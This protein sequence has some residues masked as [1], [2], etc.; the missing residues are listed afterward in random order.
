MGRLLSIA[1]SSA[2]WLFGGIGRIRHE[3]WEIWMMRIGLALLVFRATPPVPPKSVQPEPHGIARF[4][5]LTFLSRPDVYTPLWW[6]LHGALV[7]Y[8]LGLA[9]GPCLGFILAFVVATNSLELSQAFV[10]HSTQMEGLVLLAQLAATVWAFAAGRWRGGAVAELR[11]SR[12]DLMMDWTRQGIVASYVV[13]GI[14]KLVN[15]DGEWLNRSVF[16][17]LQV[18][19]AQAEHYYTSGVQ[20]NP[21]SMAFL[22]ALSGWPLLAG[23]FLT[24]GL[25][26]EL[27]AFLG[28]W[29]RPLGLIVGL[30]L[31]GFHV[32]LGTLMY[33]P[34]YESR[35]FVML[36]LVNP[37]WW[38]WLV[39]RRASGRHPLPLT[40]K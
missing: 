4:L 33:L 8:A 20:A 37:A 32:M 2:R 27:F 12:D 40:A 23:W 10:G 19:K 29:N 9:V 34:F 13:A 1:G 30:G 35:D 18:H 39:L 14:T 22:S 36:F 7:S 25:L 38:A 6:V 5:D 15:S 21:A 24:G 26:L 11:R 28:A 16:F 3:R 17:V 31:I